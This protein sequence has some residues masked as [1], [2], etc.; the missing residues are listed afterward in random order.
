MKQKTK[1]KNFENIGYRCRLSAHESPICR[2][3]SQKSHIGR[4][5]LR[6]KEKNTTFLGL[7]RASSTR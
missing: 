6:S 2:Y 3:R 7:I 5:L 4:S 1:S